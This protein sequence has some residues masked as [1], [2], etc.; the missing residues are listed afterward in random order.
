MLWTC[1]LRCTCNLAFAGAAARVRRDRTGGATGVAT[2]LGHSPNCI[3]ANRPGSA[4]GQAVRAHRDGG[5]SLV[6]IAR[7]PIS[8]KQFHRRG[9]LVEITR[10][11]E[12]DWAALRICGRGAEGCRLYDARRRAARQGNRDSEN[13]KEQNGKAVLSHTDLLPRRTS[14][15]NSGCLLSTIYQIFSRIPRSCRNQTLSSSTGRA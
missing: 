15:K 11:C 7:A 4:L 14:G 10:G 2:A 3:C 6:L 5:S 13:S 12:L 1:Q 8:R 9:L